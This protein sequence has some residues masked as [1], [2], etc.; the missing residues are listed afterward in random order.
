VGCPING[1]RRKQQAV[2]QTAKSGSRRHWQQHRQLAAG[3]KQQALTQTAN[4]DSNSSRRQHR[5]LPAASMG[6]GAARTA[7]A[8]AAIGTILLDVTKTLFKF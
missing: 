6:P 2:T 4:S 8:S 3:T 5:Q 7:L 1:K